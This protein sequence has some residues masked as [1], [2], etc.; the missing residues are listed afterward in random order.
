MK[1]LAAWSVHL[2]ALLVGGTGLVYGWMRY[3]LEPADELALVNH[4]LE[5]RFQ[6]LHLLFAPLLVFA[7]AAI[8]NDHAWRRVQ[9]GHRPRRPTGLVLFALFF[10]MVLSGA[11]VQ[12]AA[13]E[14]A[15]T[16][17]I[18]LHA[19][20][21]TAWCAA[22]VVHLFSRQ[23]AD[24]SRTRGSTDSGP[25]LRRGNT[26]PSPSSTAPSKTSA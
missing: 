20:S 25:H 11:W 9:S 1:R 26:G 15:R 4:P 13:S 8:W 3:F 23:D 2:A 10:P 14:L 7:C 22:Y 16:L 19:G 18:W 5:P 6:H 24:A 17:A 21:G 12:V